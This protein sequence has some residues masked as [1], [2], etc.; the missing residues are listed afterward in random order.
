MRISIWNLAYTFSA[1]WRIRGENLSA[2]SFSDRVLII[3]FRMAK[4]RLTAAAVG[5]SSTRRARHRVIRHL[6][7]WI[8]S[9]KRVPYGVKIVCREFYRNVTVRSGGVI[10]INRPSFTRDDEVTVGTG[11]FRGFLWEMEHFPSASRN[12]RMNIRETGLR[13]RPKMWLFNWD[14]RLEKMSSTL[15]NSSWPATFCSGDLNHSIKINGF[16]F[17]L[18]RSYSPSHFGNGVL[19]IF[20]YRLG[21]GSSSNREG[22]YLGV[23]TGTTLSPHEGWLNPV[24]RLGF[25]NRIG[26]YRLAR[27][28]ELLL[29][30]Q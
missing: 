16:K 25:C 5:K 19:R 11:F 23:K 24:Y 9:W 10:F 28:G 29:D 20:C 1:L 26:G 4:W 17:I 15:Y 7:R 18:F 6:T 13:V 30:I 2:V 22:E 27:L 12:I 3:I 14:P 8:F 21:D